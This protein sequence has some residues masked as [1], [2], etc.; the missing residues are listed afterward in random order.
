MRRVT[1]ARLELSAAV[2]LSQLILRVQTC[3]NYCQ[4]PVH[5]WTDSAVALACIRG[6]PAKW[7][8]FVGNRVAL[9]QELV[10]QA[11]WHH[12]PGTENPADLAS[13]GLFPRELRDRRLWW[14]GPGWLRR[15]PDSW[16]TGFPEVPDGAELEA[17]C[18]AGS[19][20]VRASESWNL[21]KKYS[22][23]NRLL[24]VTA[25]LNRAVAILRRRAKRTDF[26]LELTPQELEKAMK[27]WVGETQRLHFSADL[28]ILSE[29]KDVPKSSPLYRLHPFIDSDGLIRLGGR[30]Q[31]TSLEY[32]LKH[33]LILPRASEFSSLVTGETHKLTLHGGV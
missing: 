20:T 32:G 16:P 5:L 13:R 25:R 11:Q 27:F 12:V 28:K 6:D 1:I 3:L 19:H 24:R 18:V 14:E 17:W 4:L 26:P 15:P 33:P 9:I 31:L 23:L 10:P 21:V 22:S 8:D 29:R 30:I 7:K 2:L